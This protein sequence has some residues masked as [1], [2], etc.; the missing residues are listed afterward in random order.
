M[1]A[2]RNRKIAQTDASRKKLKDIQ[3]AKELWQAA[4]DA[5]TEDKLTKTYSGP[6]ASSWNPNI[7][8]APTHIGAGPL[9][10]QPH[11]TDTRGDFA[12]K[13]SGNPF[14]HAHGGL[15]TMFTRRR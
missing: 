2:I 12:G 14:G 1:H 9:H 13:G 3:K 11:G 5:T 7:T 6:E 8:T 10:G 4:Q 15:A